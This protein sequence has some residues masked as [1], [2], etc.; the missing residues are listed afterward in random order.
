MITDRLRR[1][2]QRALARGAPHVPYTEDQVWQRGRGL[3]YLCG[4]SL[5]REDFQIEH[6]IPIT[7]GGPDVLSNVMPAHARCN[8]VKGTRI[9]TLPEGPLRRGLQQ[10]LVVF[11]RLYRVG[12]PT[13][14]LAPVLAPHVTTL[15]FATVPGRAHVTPATVAE[16]RAA[17]HAPLARV[18]VHGAELRVELPR[19]PRRPV[20][21]A[22]VPRRGLR[23]GIGVAAD[24]RPVGIDLETPAHV[25][26]AGQTGSGKSVLLQAIAAQLA[27]AGARL[28][29]VDADGTTFEP[30]ARLAAL[31]VAVARD[32]DAGHDAVVY[33]RQ[34]M[35][36]RPVS[37]AQPP[38]VLVVDEIHTLRMDT[39]ALIQDVAQ[40]G[41]KRR[42]SI[43]VATHRP[44][45]DV[46]TPTLTDQCAW[47]I[48]GRVQ[49][50][51]AS[52]LIIGQT[53][54][55]H[56]GAAG[57]M[58][59]AHGGGVVRFQ[60]ARGEAADW[61][62]LV[63]TRTEPEAAPAAAVEDPRYQRQPND[64][65]VAW[66]V[67]RFRS[68]GS[69]PSAKAVKDVFGGNTGRAMRARDEALQVIGG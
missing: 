51:K 58:L 50:P 41:R 60:A 36:A 61:A 63:M 35:D 29:L 7:R 3:C 55:Q 19:W 20:P 23:L 44:T 24:N 45:R 13:S 68:T 17:L 30:F 47:R 34:Q 9:V 22:T 16:V 27:A 31:E 5:A 18:Y 25:L 59:L 66:L 6:T 42:V 40:R 32:V 1:N 54:A 57:D 28:V 49:T 37:L 8:Q 65:R 52:E 38:L 64:E 33:V 21:L 39:R 2:A 10:T 48:A 4:R 62:R 69:R 14:P 67:E 56:L 43:V 53:G 46:L 12:F 26:I 11:A 15:R